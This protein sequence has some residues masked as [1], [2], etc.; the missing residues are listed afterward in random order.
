[1]IVVLVIPEKCLVSIAPWECLRANVHVGILWSLVNR[2]LVRLVFPM[3]CPLNP[4]VCGCD[5]ECGDDDAE[6]CELA[7]ALLG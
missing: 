2:R 7:V 1:M 6:V 3:L 4:C 5:N